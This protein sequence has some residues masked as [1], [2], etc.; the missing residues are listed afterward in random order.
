MTKHRLDTRTGLGLDQPISERWQGF[1]MQ[2]L[3]EGNLH[4]LAAGASDMEAVAKALRKAGAPAIPEVGK[5]VDGN[6]NA[7]LMWCGNQQWF[8]HVGD[9]EIGRQM[10]GNLSSLTNLTDQ[11]DGWV[12]MR[13]EGDKTRKVLEKLCPID[14]DPGVFPAGACARAPFEGLATLIACEDAEAGRYLLLFQRSSSR[15]FVEH[16]RHAAN[17]SCGGKD[18]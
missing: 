3:N 12:V 1:S 9:A 14:L 5:S 7:R 15:S 17:S 13:I 18:H 8:L 11:S 2:E 4:L 10:A 6:G 16:L